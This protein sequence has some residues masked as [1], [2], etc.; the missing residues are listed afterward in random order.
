[1][2]L[3]SQL[4]ACAAVGS[5]WTGATL[6]YDRHNLYKKIDDYQIGAR[7]NHELFADKRLRCEGCAID[8]A[9]FHR[10]LLLTGHVPNAELRE[11]A[12]V[13]MESISGV[14][15]KYNQIALKATSG[16]SIQDAW[17]T[18]KIRSQVM[19]DAEIDP[20]QFKII[21]ADG[22]VYIMGDMLPG[23]AKR[24][25]RIARRT[26]GV[27]RVVKLFNVYQVVAAP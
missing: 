18:A 26:D 1:M 19:V 25:V 12:N 27:V 23:Q 22:I 21:T 17:I 16:H 14:R 7:A 9:V 13:R 8:V 15:K 11:E 4:L 6:V 10:D 20:N 3:V 2:A 5:L 24:V